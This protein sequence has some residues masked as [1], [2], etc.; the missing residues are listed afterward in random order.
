MNTDFKILDL[1]TRNR[2]SAARHVCAVIPNL[3][4]IDRFGHC[5]DHNGRDV[6]GSA[7]VLVECGGYRTYGVVIHVQQARFLV[8]GD[9]TPVGIWGTPGHLGILG[10]A[11]E[12][13]RA[14]NAGGT[15][16]AHHNVVGRRA[17]HTI[18]SS[19]GLAGTGRRELHLVLIA[20][21][22]VLGRLVV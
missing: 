19:Y 18:G 8:N 15:V 4:I 7:V 20:C 11:I 1:G 21:G 3:K 13:K 22:R 5:L 6:L 9:I 16:L 10:Q 17:E 14:R 12:L 2:N